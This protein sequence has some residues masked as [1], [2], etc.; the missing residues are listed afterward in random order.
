VRQI[1]TLNTVAF[2]VYTRGGFLSPRCKE[3]LTVRVK[4]QNWTSQIP[5]ETGLQDELKASLH[6]LSSPFRRRRLRDEKRGCDGEHDCG[7]TG[8]RHSIAIGVCCY[9]YQAQG[10]TVFSFCVQSQAFVLHPLFFF[11][12]FLLRKLFFCSRSLCISYAYMLNSSSEMGRGRYFFL[13]DCT[14][15]FPDFRVMIDL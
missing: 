4:S 9:A 5:V 11:P 13:S 7:C 14:C 12:L 8:P 10:E 15:S 2:R 1:Q 6:A 3:S